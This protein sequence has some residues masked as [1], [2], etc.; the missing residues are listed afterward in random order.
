MN[1]YLMQPRDQHGRN[2]AIPEYPVE[3]EFLSGC[4]LLL[5]SPAL[6]EIGLLDEDFFLYYEDL[7]WCIRFRKAG[8]KLI[9]VPAAKLW[10]KVAVSSK[11]SDLPNE[12]YWMA[13][14][15]IHY[16]QKHIRG[17]AWIVVIPWRFGSAIKTSLR[18]IFRGQYTA[19]KLYWKGLRDG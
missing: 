14:S 6:K 13:Y 8:W 7:D 19:L 10:H 11:G 18:L 12:R 16:F 5:Q 1:W 9:I 15:S 4:C 3:R 17:F 2:L